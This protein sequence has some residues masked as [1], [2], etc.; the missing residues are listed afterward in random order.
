[1]GKKSMPYSAS[2]RCIKATHKFQ[3]YSNLPIHKNNLNTQSV[4][5][6]FVGQLLGFLRLF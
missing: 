5:P 3:V 1:M 6:V 4:F 2:F